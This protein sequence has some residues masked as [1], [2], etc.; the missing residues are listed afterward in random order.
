MADAPADGG[1]RYPTAP[2]A[3][4]ARPELTGGRPVGVL[5]VHGF[6]GSPA[7]M[8]PWAHA[9]HEHGYAVEVPLLPGHGTRWQDLNQVT[10]QQWYDEAA[11]AFDRLRNQ[12]EAVVVGGLSMGGSV[13]LRLAEERGDQVAGIVLVNPFVSSTRKELKALPVLKH[14]V[15]SLRGVVNDIKKP[16]Q[17]EHGYPRLPLKGLAAV[18][19]LWQAVVPDLGRVTQPLLYFRSTTDHVIDASSSPTVLRGVSSTDVEERLL[20]DSYHV[21]TLDH[22]AERIQQESAEFVARVTG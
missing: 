16:D 17:D 15:P 20:A 21:A 8:K 6:T 22:D 19:G 7:S 14:V 5:L 1:L 11:A 18:T 9:L 12:C 13:V 2:L 3:L 10:W 4:P